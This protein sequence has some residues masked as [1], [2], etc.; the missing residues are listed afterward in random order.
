M[1]EKR[2]PRPGEEYDVFFI[3]GRRE[4]F[5][6]WWNRGD[7]ETDLK[8]RKLIDLYNPK[9]N[10]IAD[11]KPPLPPD[12]LSYASWEDE[13]DL[14]GNQIVRLL[15]ILDTMPVVLKFVD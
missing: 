11:P 12:L 4:A 13:Y 14:A 10:G 8:E 7:L 3:R 5:T 1:P 6:D 9:V 2:R 15:I